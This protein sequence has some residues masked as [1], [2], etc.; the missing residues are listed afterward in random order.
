LWSGKVLEDQL[1]EDARALKNFAEYVAADNRI[2]Q[3]LLPIRDG[4]FI[5]Q[6]IT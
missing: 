2:D 3:L 6:R 4:L 1:D 5:C